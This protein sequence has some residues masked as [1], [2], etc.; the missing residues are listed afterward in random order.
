M[1]RFF[2]KHPTAGNLLMILFVVLGV[3]SLSSLR[4]ETF[5]DFSKDLVKITVVYPGATAADIE[6]AICRRIED[7]VDGISYVRETIAEAREGLGTVTVEMEPGGEIDTFLQDIKS[8]VDAIDDFPDQA[9]DPVVEKLNQTDRVVAIA[10]S[11]P[12]TVTDLKHYAEHLKDR[13]KRDAGV[14]LVT[15]S[16]FSDRQIRIQIPAGILMQYGLSVDDVASVIARQ[17]VDLPAGAIETR[18]QDIL[19]RFTDERKSPLEFND[20]VVVAGSSGAEIRLGDI[21]QIR[22]VFELAEEKFIFNGR[23]AGLLEISKTKT[24]D[25]LE[26]Y[27]A[28]KQFVE[29]ERHIAPP[30]VLLSLTQDVSSIVADRLHLLTTNGLQGLVLV[31]LTMWLFF[32]LRLSFWVAM[33]LP[34]SFLGAFF[35]MP[36][37]GYSLNMLTM[38]GLLIGLGLL[39][40][41]AI[42]I[43]ENVATHLDRGKPALTAVIEGVREVKN[44]V[45]ASFTTTICVFGPIAF[46][47]GDMGKVLRVMPVVLILVLAVSLVEA[48]WI[49]PNHL[50]HALAHQ[51]SRRRSRFR[52]WF[53]ERLERFRERVLGAVVDRV[54]RWRYLFVGMVIGAFILSVG[55]LAAGIL[56]FKAFPDVDGD[57]VQ[58]RILLPQGT[59]LATTETLVGRVVD[60]IHQV[61]REF[62]PDQPEGMRLIQNVS[63]QYNHNSDA[64]ESGAHLATVSADLLSAELR[65]ARIDDILNRWRAIT[66][67]VPDVIALKFG[68]S[69]F[70]PAGRPIDIRLSG[71]DLAE[72]KSASLALQEW[73][74]QFHGVFDLSDDLRPGKPEFRLRMREGAKALGLDAQAVASQL[75]SAYHGRTVSEIQVGRESYEIDVRLRDE[76]KSSLA[77]LTDFHVTLPDGKQAPLESVALLSRDRGYARIAA[78]DGQRTVTIQGDVDA[79]IANTQQIMTLMKE[80]FL[81]QLRTSHPGVRVSLEGEAKESAATGASLARGFVIG[82]VGIFILLS[83]QFRSYI[84]PATVMVAIPLAFIGVIVGHLLMGLDLSMPSMM[85]AVSLAG[86]VVNDSI[87]LVEFIKIHRRRGRQTSDAAR[88]ASRERFRAVLITTLTTVAGLLPLLAEK[89]LQAQ[90]LIPLAASIVFGMLASTVLVLLVVPALYTILD[91][92][93]L[94]VRLSGGNGHPSQTAADGAQ[95]AE[96]PISSLSP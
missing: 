64:Y 59:P 69:G 50:A 89:S 72:L 43:A 22:D 6:D 73:L 47:E 95:S 2:A 87:L 83:F 11:G 41:D 42:V 8:E 25:T 68:E 46:L 44:G 28:V 27:D 33:G 32:N 51:E 40:D 19:I 17:S 9:E 94:T 80:T 26:M 1:I 54:I 78:V 3:M 81:P 38:V 71:D 55:T 14:S 93:G 58:A 39:M 56:K 92:F 12:M 4:R 84:E 53:E 7:A 66:G 52:R 67:R 34:V 65:N 23:R 90:V 91:D 85:G 86:I 37:I 48:F 70:G 63:V 49:L 96:A 24:E 29:Q 82:L 10:V 61:D 20:L 88:R 36:Q 77:N 35:V 79:R 15:V 76:D 74:N 45:L 31:F 75:R 60:A 21:A 30:G 18:D 57:L 16:G 13:L 62:S 5:P